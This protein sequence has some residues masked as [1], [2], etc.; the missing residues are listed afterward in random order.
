M[1]APFTI[2]AFKHTVRWKRKAIEG[3]QSE[4][5]TGPSLGDRQSSPSSMEVGLHAALPLGPTPPCLSLFLHGGFALQAA[6]KE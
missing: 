2:A 4:R 6:P 1:A 3:P 5:T